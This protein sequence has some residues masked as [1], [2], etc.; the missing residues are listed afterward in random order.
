MNIW[1]IRKVF[2]LKFFLSAQ[3]A[4]LDAQ[5]FKQVSR[6][7]REMVSNVSTNAQSFTNSEFAEKLQAFFDG[8]FVI[9][10]E[11]SSVSPTYQCFQLLGQRFINR[12]QRIP[13]LSFLNGSIPYEISNEVAEKKVRRQWYQNHKIH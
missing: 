2:A 5:V 8:D 3:D 7:T 11:N 6:Q 13:S 12:F 10:Q 4:M 9:N 1:T